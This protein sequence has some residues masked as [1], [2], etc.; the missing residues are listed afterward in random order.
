MNAS[1]DAL[2]SVIMPVYNVEQYIDKAIE[3]VLNQTYRNFE[4]II[5]NDGSTDSSKAHIEKYLY[6]ERIV[7]IDKVN[8]GLSSARNAGLDVFKGSY[9]TFIDSDD[10]L[11]EC[12]LEG[13]YTT[14][15]EKSVD[16][17]V[18]NLMK[19][20]G[21]TPESKK[22]EYETLVYPARKHVI[23]MFTPRCIGA[24]AWGKLYKAEHFSNLRFPEGR[25][26]ED[27]FTIPFVMYP[28][29]NVA[30]IEEPLYYYRQREGSILSSYKEA[31]KDEVY[32]LRANV[33]YAKEHHDGVY[34]M[35]ARLNEV[36]SYLEI[37]HRF[38]KYGYDFKPVKADFKGRILIDFF[39]MILPIT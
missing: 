33:D 38:K 21:D 14:L 29:E 32:A 17:S 6:D 26:F 3:S 28:C 8:G 13:L 10:Y 15:L 22:D 4:F 16:I 2:I 9:I 37:R 5:V 25:C 31:R 20:Y 7:F 23:A 12:Y 1:K 24:Y 19:V 11:D 36:R 30:Y 18:C 39:K 35:Y 27:I 34:C